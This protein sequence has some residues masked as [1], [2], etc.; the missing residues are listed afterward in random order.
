[1]I[2]RGLLVVAD[3]SKTHEPEP[4]GNSSSV[5]KNGEVQLSV[6]CRAFSD[7]RR[8]VQYT[9]FLMP[10][11]I[12]CTAHAACTKMNVFV[13]V[14]VQFLSPDTLD[15]PFVELRDEGNHGGN[16]FRIRNSD[17]PGVITVTSFFAQ[18]WHLT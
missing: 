16:L 6:E 13:T 12:S 5:G 1:M 7:D 14:F 8:H 17:A 2:I 18:V 10:I 4:E 15:I 3:K 9:L 11:I